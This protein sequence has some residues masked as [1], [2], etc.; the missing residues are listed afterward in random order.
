MGRAVS[1]ESGSEGRPLPRGLGERIVQF[2]KDKG[3]NL[4]QLAERAGV[5]KSYL[6]ALENTDTSVQSSRRPSAETLYSIA[7]ALGV[8]MA[9]LLGRKALAEP[10]GPPPHSLME[11]AKQ[12]G[13][14]AADVRM[15]NTIRFRGEPPK[16]VE[17]WQHI[18]N[19][20]R[21]SEP[22]DDD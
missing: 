17:R 8:T 1:D 6:W 22:M 5:S 4:S 11:F 3:L 2:R 13:L 19:A 20:I 15:L 18:Y 16:T 21:L 9:D 14:P 10:D 7:Q 12:R